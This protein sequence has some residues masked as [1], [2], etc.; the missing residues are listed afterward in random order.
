V[1]DGRLRL[2][3]KSQL[4]T[5][6]GE[7]PTLVFT[8]AAAAGS[9]K[10][11][12]L[13]KRGVEVVSCRSRRGVL[14]LSACLRVLADREVTNV[15]VEGGPRVLNSFF[16]VGLVDEALIYTAP[17]LIGGQDAPHAL[18]GSGA[19][20]VDTAIAA[21]TVQISRCGPD[22]VHR[23]RFTDPGQVLKF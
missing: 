7:L 1:L 19:A 17:I 6:A 8:A 22:T 14:D 20:R 11:Q 15:L 13:R 16:R 21:R 9:A 4:V 5:T 3:E 10:A 2:S 23:L 12:R 18:M